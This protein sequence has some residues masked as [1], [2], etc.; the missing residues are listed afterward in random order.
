MKLLNY[1]IL[2]A[3]FLA[4]LPG[5]AQSVNVLDLSIVPDTEGER[6]TITLN[7][8]ASYRPFL[9]E[10][11]A[12]LVVDLPPF[13][14]GVPAASLQNYQGNLVRNIRYARFNAQ[15]S[16]IVFDLSQRVELSDNT[17]G[18]GS[19]PSR[20]LVFHLRGTGEMET[21]PVSG[22]SFGQVPLPEGKPSPLASWK[23]PLIIIDAGH[24]GKDTGAIGRERTR[25]KDITL[26]YARELA[27]VLNESGRFEAKLTRDDD[28]FI[29]LRDRVKIAR[30]QK[31]DLFLSIHADSAPTIQ[32][33][34]LS[35]YTLSEEASDKEAA[36]LAVQE[37]K[38][39]VLAGFDLSHEDHDVA[40]ILIDL[41]QRD[42]TNK[43]ITL[44]ESMVQAMQG[45]IAL[46]PNT[47]RFAG[48]AVLTAPDMPAVLIEIGFLSNPKEE[49]L[50]KTT[51][52]RREVV[53]GIMRGI[54]KYFAIPRE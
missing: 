18:N 33:R 46:L 40:N 11:P 44:A 26:Q 16:R 28:R 51:Q 35:V 49:K 38:V 36:A 22:T 42:T 3:L 17:T 29:L 54:E 8:P 45:K 48:F 41:A 7:Q 19:R 37:N 6:V 50:I 39:D 5:F 27:R 53:E 13:A 25:E 9:L 1:I 52:H 30:E 10:D 20:E 14:W 2:I 47:H 15:T 43:S 12:R 21:A 31:G 23:K 32:A 4:P 34:G 24:G